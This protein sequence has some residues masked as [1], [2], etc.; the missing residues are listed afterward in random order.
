M[1]W[2]NCPGR[3]WLKDIPW[4]DKV[5]VVTIGSFLPA[6]DCYPCISYSIQIMANQ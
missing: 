6:P 4:P 2:D 5:S 1:I 3:D